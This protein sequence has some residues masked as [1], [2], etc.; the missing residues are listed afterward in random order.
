MGIPLYT[1]RD[2]V[3]LTKSTLTPS[4]CKT[5]PLSRIEQHPLH[6][7]GLPSASS[8]SS[9]SS[10]AFVRGRPI[11]PTESSA[12][13]QD[14]LL[15]TLFSEAADLALTAD[16]QSEYISA[17]ECLRDMEPEHTSFGIGSEPATELEPLGRTYVARQYN[18]D[19][20]SRSGARNYVARR[21]NRLERRQ[22]SE[23]TH[24][25]SQ[26]SLD[27]ELEFTRTLA[28]YVQRLQNLRRSG[29]TNADPHLDMEAADRAREIEDLVSIQMERTQSESESRNNYRSYPLASGTTLMETGYEPPIDHRNSSGLTAFD[30]IRNQIRSI[31]VVHDS[32]LQSVDRL[33]MS[34][35]D[36]YIS[37]SESVYD[38]S[39][40]SHRGATMRSGPSSGRWPI[41]R[42]NNSSRYYSPLDL[43]GFYSSRLR[44]RR[45]A[46]VAATNSSNYP[47]SFGLHENN[48]D[49]S[50]NSFL[51][52]S[53]PE[54]RALALRF[55]ALDVRLELIRLA[56]RELRLLESDTALALEQLIYGEAR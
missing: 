13:S 54:V 51:D 31:G 30:S 2:E 9:S 24:S 19:H 36:D 11:Y 52:S 46:D 20:L 34:A 38:L 40:H 27:A 18:L 1:P 55:G 45:S 35:H 47:Y 48:S 8:S 15:A 21:D 29:Y 32:M 44:L 22:S 17:T 42:R 4:R 6:S 5:Y 7:P 53:D 26:R 14:L 23:L 25:Q 28:E 49:D 39:G 12:Y 56:R 43:D 33:E 37:D 16:E 10:G 50:I 41:S 3:P